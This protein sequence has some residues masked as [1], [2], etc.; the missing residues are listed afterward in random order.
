[1]LLAYEMNDKPLT[2]EHGYPLRAVVPGYAGVR[3][4]KW[5]TSIV[6]QST[7]SE[8]HFQ[9]HEYKLF[10]PHVSK[11]TA[12]WDKGMTINELPINAAIC[13]PEAYAA[14]KAGALTLKGY[15]VVSG[16]QI[17][18]V[19][20]SIDGG[21]TW[22]QANIEHEAESPWSWVFWQ[23]PVELPKG[24]HELAVRAWDWAGQ[25]Q[26][27]LPDDTWNFKGYMSAAWHRINVSVG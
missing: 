12:D 20:V 8:G 14:L 22:Q 19:D 5:L 9:A 10:P 15:A 17:S 16:R 26:P 25:T 11:E 21:R 13:F 6:V 27:A 2:A 3:S 7:P 4:P 24:D 23:L 1:V 18:R